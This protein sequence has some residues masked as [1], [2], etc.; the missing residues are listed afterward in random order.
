MI[1]IISNSKIISNKRM[2]IK[3]IMKRDRRLTRSLKRIPKR[4]KKK[5]MHNKRKTIMIVR[6]VKLKVNSRRLIKQSRVN[7][8][9]QNKIK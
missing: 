3:T 5:I 9:N 2:K 8:S 1:K 6:K 7:K 4:T